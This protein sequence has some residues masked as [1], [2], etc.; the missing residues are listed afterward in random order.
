[1][2]GVLGGRKNTVDRR[3]EIGRTFEEGIQSGGKDRVLEDAICG[4]VGKSTTVFE[5]RRQCDAKG[6]SG[7]KK[8]GVC[9]PQFISKRKKQCRPR[10][11]KGISGVSTQES[12]KKKGG[13]P[14]DRKKKAPAS[15][16]EGFARRGNAGR[17]K[18]KICR[19]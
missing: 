14:P 18:K 9:R 16:D 4:V 10:K 13:L 17:Q 11:G 19:F 6:K 8:G 15:S 2:C 5:K 7:R 12:C 1:L 3:G